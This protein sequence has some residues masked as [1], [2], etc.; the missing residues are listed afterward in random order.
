MRIAI[1]IP[2]IR[3]L[4]FLSEWGDA[5]GECSFVIVE[6]H[7]TKEITLPKIPLKHVSHYTWKDIQNDFGD[8]EWIFSRKNAGIRSYGFWKAYKEGAEVIITL[9]DDCYPVDRDL[10]SQHV[11]NLQTKAPESWFSTYPDRRFTCTRGFPYS[12]REKRPVMISHGLWTNKIDLDG[13]TQRDN[14]DIDLPPYPSMVQFVPPGLYFPMCSMNLAFTRAATPVMY[15]P[16]MGYDP[17]GRAWGY[18]RFDD[19]WAG[20]FAKKIC[21]HLGVSV[22]NGSPFVEHR[23][24]SDALT[25]MRK[26]KE[27]VKTNE[28]LWKIVDRV[29]LTQKTPA[30]CYKELANKAKFP[31]ESYF[32]KLKE[33]MNIWANLFL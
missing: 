18:D 1:V 15:F 2:T 32:T 12:V 25:N 5:F 11:K 26:E 24:A 23:K 8:T 14:P 10:V 7:N 31:N 13:V 33:A 21:D 28:L 29:V 16:P 22:L 6:D 9:D 20:I 17:E 27:G 19:I 3:S 30:L 4:T